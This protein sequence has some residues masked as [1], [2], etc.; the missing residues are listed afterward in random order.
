MNLVT[1]LA[2]PSGNHEPIDL[3]DTCNGPLVHTC[4]EASA[5]KAGDLRG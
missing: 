3:C 2:Q 5:S 1:Y 4:C